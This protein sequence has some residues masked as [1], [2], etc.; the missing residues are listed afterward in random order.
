MPELVPLA[1]FEDPEGFP[2][3]LDPPR[4]PQG[5]LESVSFDELPRHLDWT[6]APAPLAAKPALSL[7]VSG[8]RYAPDTSRSCPTTARPREARR[9]GVP[10]LPL[11]HLS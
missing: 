1:D 2:G 3:D 7:P 10:I 11:Q 4:E 6:L 9:F 8:R 5:P